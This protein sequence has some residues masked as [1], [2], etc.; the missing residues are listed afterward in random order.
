[1]T[2]EEVKKDE[3]AVMID[4]DTVVDDLFAHRVLAE[5][6][7]QVRNKNPVHLLVII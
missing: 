5:H 3:D 4:D 1:M 6:R 2:E 7:D